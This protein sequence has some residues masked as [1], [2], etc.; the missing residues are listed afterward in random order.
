ML[1]MYEQTGVVMLRVK[2]PRTHQLP[3]SQSN[4]SDDVWW[5]DCSNFVGQEVV[6][7]EK[8]DGESVAI[9]PDGFTHARSIDSGHH[10]SR[11]WIKAFAP[12]FAWKIPEG[13]RICAE[14]LTAWH[15]VF[16]TDLPTYLFVIG[17]YDNQ[18]CLSWDDTLALVKHLNL[19][20]VPVLYR[21]IWDEETIKGLWT[22]KGRFPTFEA[23]NDNPKFPG[24]FVPCDAEGY[25]VRLANAFQYEDFHKSVGKFVRSSHVKG[26]AHWADRKPIFNLLLS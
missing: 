8:L 1:S 19:I 17:I 5:K 7:S 3:F 9:Y 11:S 26:N 6:V 21:G 4:S 25:V 10:A 14:N 15:S 16:Y 12:T 22:G 20:T 24:D 2:Y 18:T 23:K 13:H